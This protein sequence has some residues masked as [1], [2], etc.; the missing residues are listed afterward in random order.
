MEPE[1]LYRQLGQLVADMPRD[2]LGQAPI[3]GDTHRWLGRA[4]VLV[5]ESVDDLIGTDY[6]GFTTAVD[7]LQGPLREQT[8]HQ[9]VAILHRALARAEM[10]APAAAQGAFIPVGA[11][12]DVLQRVGKILEEASA[13]VFVVD[14]Y[15]N[16]T[17]LTDFAPLARERIALR[18]LADSHSTKKDTLQPAVGRWVKQYANLRPLEVRLT[19]PRALHDRLIFIDRGRKV[20]ILTQSLKDFGTRSP[21]SFLR[22]DD[23]DMAMMKLEVYE[24]EWA[25]AQRL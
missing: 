21:G 9:I 25:A 7:H 1:A 17:I 24:R 15:M 3:S 8:A 23:R 6:I 2:L 10:K 4:A 12:F 14:P 5:K 19:R 20:W 11:L 18:L 22:V 16:H 13:D